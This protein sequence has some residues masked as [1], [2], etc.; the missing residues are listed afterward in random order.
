[1][2][3]TTG[4]GGHGGSL[5]FSTVLAGLSG[6]LQDWLTISSAGMSTFSGELLSSL[7]TS[8]ARIEC[9]HAYVFASRFAEYL[10]LLAV[11]A[12]PS[13]PAGLVH[14]LPHRNVLIVLFSILSNLLRDPGNII[15]LERQRLLLLV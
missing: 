12:E 5:V 6:S 13:C 15:L 11:L 8:G 3:D 7:A 10:Y 4:A 1:M 14:S 2:Q 9:R